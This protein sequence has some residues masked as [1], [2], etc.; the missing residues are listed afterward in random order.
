M[1]ARRDSELLRVDSGQVDRL[2]ADEPSFASALAR[3]LAVQLQASQGLDVQPSP[4]PET[5]AWSRSRAR[6][7]RRPWRRC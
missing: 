6:P 1:R 2:L 5:V 7:K 3:S 4:I